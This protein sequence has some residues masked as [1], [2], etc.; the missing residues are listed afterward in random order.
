MGAYG[1]SNSL[2]VSIRMHGDKKL[3]NIRENILLVLE[4]SH[5]DLDNSL[6]CILVFY[7]IFILYIFIRKGPL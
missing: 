4:W 6:I 2:V 7:L 3:M 1:D 5:M